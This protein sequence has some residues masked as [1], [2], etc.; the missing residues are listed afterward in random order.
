MRIKFMSCLFSILCLFLIAVAVCGESLPVFVS[1]DGA[2]ALVTDSL[3]RGLSLVR[4]KS[5]EI[6]FVTSSLNAGYYATISPDNRFV[7]FKS[8]ERTAAGII[9]TPCLFDIA[10]E[11]AFALWEPSPVCGTPAIAPNGSIA[12]TA[13][14]DLIL[15]D[16]GLNVL[17]IIDLGHH[18]NLLAFSPAGDQIAF[19]T[20]EHQIAIV[21]LSNGAIQIITDDAQSYWGAKFSPNGDKVL[22]RSADGGIFCANPQEGQF[23]AIGKGESPDW[24]DNDTIAFV[25]KTIF[26]NRVVKT[27][28]ISAGMGGGEN[29]ATIA[30]GDADAVIG[31][32]KV[33]HASGGKIKIGAI[34]KGKALWLDEVDAPDGMGGDSEGAATEGVIILGNTVQITGVPYVH[35][36]Y[37]TPE[38]FAGSWAC[39]ATSAVMALAYYGCFYYWDCW[40]M[41][42][43]SH[44]SHYGNYIAD[45]YTYNGH[46]FNIV[47][48]DP[49][50]EYATGGYGY[51]VQNNW[52]N[53]KTHMAEYLSYHGPSSSVDWSPTFAKAQT[54]INNGYLFV[55]LNSLTTS[56]HYC[57]CIGYYTD[58]YSLIFNDPYGNKNTPGYPSYD[59]AG[60]VYDWPGYNYGNQNLTTVHC[61]IYARWTVQPTPTPPPAPVQVIVD[62]ADAA[63]TLSGAWTISSNVRGWYGSNYA[64]SPTGNGALATFYL[65]IAEAGNYDVSA[66]WTSA[67]DRSTKTPYKVYYQGGSATR[68]FDQTHWGGRF[69]LIGNYPFQAG[70]YR[71]ELSAN[72][73]D[74]RTKYVI[75]DAV[76]ALKT[77][78]VPTPTPTPIPS[79]MFVN[80]IAMTSGRSGSNYFA[81]ATVWIKSESGADVSGATVT[82][83]WTGA[84]SGTSTGTTGADGKVTLKSPSKKN[85]GT[86]NFCVTGAS[87]VAYIYD[88]SMNIET[89]DTI[90]AP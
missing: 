58:Q 77:S 69:Q 37:D 35:Q 25:K 90:T 57:T 27:E 29:S 86:F 89:C 74:K 85:G 51:I 44:T 22:V 83:Q 38:W 53:T 80:D 41:S 39:G 84:V 75:A 10:E 59:G 13:G 40:C 19:N 45:T 23:L 14:K 33:A 71:V 60:A 87:A 49:A 52:E 20:A 9:Q 76:R 73:G 67:S 32:G 68:T 2:L 15:L 54:E 82:G 16:A 8:T 36:V 7:C 6:I 62:N 4:V 12:F 3:H 30:E 1:D 66:L 21:D 47:E 70:Q 24:E 26:K 81:N 63:C 5:G 56:G 18:V 79:K 50:D 64:V 42:P 11:R 72:T 48:T 61:F 78:A 17:N 34:A 46:T 55:V 65:N 31:G 43:T 88:P 28:I